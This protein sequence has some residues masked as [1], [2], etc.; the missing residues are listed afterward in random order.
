MKEFFIIMKDPEIATSCH[1]IKSNDI[2]MFRLAAESF[3]APPNARLMAISESRNARHKAGRHF[4]FALNAVDVS[5]RVPEISFLSF[6]TLLIQ[7]IVY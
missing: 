1:A 6:N 4:A 5:Q 7:G 3:Q 2:S